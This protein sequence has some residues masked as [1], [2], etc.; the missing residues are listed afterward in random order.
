MSHFKTTALAALTLST[1]MGLSTA[2]HAENPFTQTELSSG[3]MQVAMAE[4]KCG[5]GKC[6]GAK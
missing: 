3:Y 2:A 4:G 5:E 6:G 1:A